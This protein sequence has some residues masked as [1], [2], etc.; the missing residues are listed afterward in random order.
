MNSLSKHTRVLLNLLPDGFAMKS[1]NDTGTNIYKF[2]KAIAMYYV[3]LE[4][5]LDDVILELG[6]TTTE[7]LIDRWEQEYGIPDDYIDVA[8]TLAD[9]RNNILLKKGGLNLLNIDDFRD[10]ATSLGYTIIIQTAT[11]V[12]FPPYDVPFYPLG[13]PDAYFLVIIKGDFTDVN[14]EYLADFYESLLAINVG[15]LLIDTSP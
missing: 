15:L 9:R 4:E 10:L 1:K 8:S 14:I 6:I 5:D 2:W 3:I 7:D 12:R 11:T 13:T